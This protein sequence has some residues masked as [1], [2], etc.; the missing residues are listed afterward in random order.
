MAC[1]SNYMKPNDFEINLS[2]VFLLLDELDG[3]LFKEADYNRGSDKRVYNR[4]LPEGLLDSKVKELCSRLKT[5]TE[6]EIRE[7]SLELQMWWRDHKRADI[8]REKTENKL[9]KEFIRK[10]NLPLFYNSGSIVD[11][12]G[13]TILTANR[14]GGT[15]PLSPSERDSMLKVV[16]KLMNKK[17]IKK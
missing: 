1:N 14:E 10:L 5:K 12:N 11:S 2:N 15:T 7:Y 8:E 16:V 13:Q 6:D 4:N 3:K 9:N 17:F